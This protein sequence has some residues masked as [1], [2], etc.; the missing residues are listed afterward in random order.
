MSNDYERKKEVG[1]TNARKHDIAARGLV[2]FHKRKETFEAGPQIDETDSELGAFEFNKQ[3]ML[4]TKEGSQYGAP[5]EFE[6]DFVL[7]GP[8]V[9]VPPG[10]G[11]SGNLPPSAVNYL[12][13]PMP[14]FMEAGQL[15]RLIIRATYLAAL[16]GQFVNFFL[17]RLDPN[18]NRFAAE[19]IL[20]GPLRMNFLEHAVGLPSANVGDMEV[21]FDQFL[22][23]EFIYQFS[24][25]FGQNVPG[26]AINQQLAMIDMLYFIVEE[27]RAVP[28]TDIL[29]MK[30]MVEDRGR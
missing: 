8:G 18:D 3:A 23:E 20:V 13:Y 17:S 28:G 12:V 4:I 15:K 5:P 30:L 26:G 27:W 2:G 9:E 14:K 21:A 7:N 29:R 10:G 22:D 11:G 1:L 6:F 25:N 19:D 16:P 24:R